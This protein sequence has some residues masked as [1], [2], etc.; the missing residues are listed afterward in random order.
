MK[1]SEIIESKKVEKAGPSYDHS[2][3]RK[4]SDGADEANTTVPISD[5]DYSSNDE[6]QCTVYNKRR[7][8]KI[9]VKGIDKIKS[10]SKKKQDDSLVDCKKKP[11]NSEYDVN[12]NESISA[13]DK[14]VGVKDCSPRDFDSENTF[15]DDSSMISN[16]QQINQI[17]DFIKSCAYFNSKNFKLK[18]RF[19][20][21]L[22]NDDF[23][24][25][26]KY[27]FYSYIKKPDCY[28]IF[29]ATY[30][31]QIQDWVNDKDEN[32]LEVLVKHD[33]KQAQ[34]FFSKTTKRLFLHE[35]ISKVKLIDSNLGETEYPEYITNLPFLNFLQISIQYTPVTKE[36][37]QIESKCI[38][39]WV[40][41][42]QSLNISILEK[43]HLYFIVNNLPKIANHSYVNLSKYFLVL[44]ND[45]LLLYSKN[46][47]PNSSNLDLRECLFL[48]LFFNNDMFKQERS[49]PACF[50]DN[51]CSLQFIKDKLKLE[52][53]RSR[54]YFLNCEKNKKCFYIQYANGDEVFSSYYK[55]KSK[56]FK[57]I[58][59]DKNGMFGNI[60][61]MIAIVDRPENVSEDQNV[62]ISFKETSNLDLFIKQY[63]K[64]SNC[65][66]S[67]EFCFFSLL[68][69]NMPIAFEEALSSVLYDKE[70]DEFF[71]VTNTS[72]N[73]LG[74]ICS[75]LNI[76]ASL[77]K[78]NKVLLLN[79]KTGIHTRF[80]QVFLLSL[81]KK[82]FVS[83]DCGLHVASNIKL[84]HR[85][86]YSFTFMCLKSKDPN[87]VPD[88]QQ[89]VSNYCKPVKKIHVD[90]C[91]VEQ[92]YFGI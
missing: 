23:I 2:L 27:L 65:M 20:Y 26:L 12:L 89:A 22:I 38:K 11:D 66:P 47:V 41:C 83:I 88:L 24:D 40:K 81:L 73:F 55:N 71:S 72:E 85:D 56:I 29:Q 30:I 68:N 91:D 33:G 77:L 31:L 67:S 54:L 28:T 58:F 10:L 76:I 57:N 84:F 51:V 7:K 87:F 53:L 69:K 50:N 45:T 18:T 80:L 37:P 48:D 49:I 44:L 32:I 36:F 39:S 46:K 70:S 42:I 63:E 9:D 34:I 8:G 62:I 4:A 25:N 1:I 90:E 3:K 61:H 14:F 15:E 75:I 74:E 13:V 21:K 92:L 6:K 17:L 16:I 19:L 59:F 78:G 43:D 64:L 35:D 52:K 82:S 86:N 5:C 79:L 60:D